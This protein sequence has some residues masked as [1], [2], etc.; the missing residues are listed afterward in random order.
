MSVRA[1]KVIKI[2]REQSPTFN[3][4]HDEKLVEYLDAT[5]HGVHA[6]LNANG[7]GML[8]FT[9]EELQ[10]AVDRAKELELDSD[11]VAALKQDIANGD[12][13]IEYECF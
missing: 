2:E 9:I 4:W 11:T 3:L 10:G 12:E 13:F 7:A 5:D 6:Q 1:Y 8:E